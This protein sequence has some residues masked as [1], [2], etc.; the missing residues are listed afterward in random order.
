[1][2]TK[3]NPGKFDCYANAEPDEPMFILLGRD[4]YAPTL[5]WLWSILREV[6]GEDPEIVKEARE[7][8]NEIVNYQIAHG[9]KTAGLAQAVVAGVLGLIRVANTAIPTNPARGTTEAL[10]KS[11]VQ[12]Q[13]SPIL[14]SEGE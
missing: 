7:C 3:N 8:V 5:V 1:M 10:I 11:V 6:D 2:G 9:R 13:P 14:K 12:G 4:R